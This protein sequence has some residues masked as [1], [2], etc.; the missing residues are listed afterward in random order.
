MRA[1][2]LAAIG[3]LQAARDLW[4]AALPY[5]P[6]SREREGVQREIERLDARLVSGVNSPHTTAGSTGSTVSFFRK[7][8]F[9]LSMLAFLGVFWSLMGPIFAVGLTLS[10]LLHEL[11][12]YFT[13][14]KFGFQPELPIFLPVGAFV[15]WRG[16]NVDPGVRSLIALAGPLMGFVSGVLAL[17]VWWATGHKVWL[18]VAE[19]AGFINLLNLVP[20][21]IFDGG[22]A[23]S[24]LGR[25][26]RIAVL[27]ASIAMFAILRDWVFLAVAGGAAVRIAG[28]DVPTQPRSAIAGYFIA[29][30][31]ANGLLSWYCGRQGLSF[32]PG[33]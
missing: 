5:L 32:V 14:K 31:A 26:Q 3:Q 9:P 20:V 33:F 11:G 25:Q 15:R 2:Q 10:V 1:R 4:A 27:A 7:L 19:Y 16:E 24:A 23:M 28:R 30:A 8:V 18:A 6:P 13:I 22:A 12:H 17:G 29:L 21:S